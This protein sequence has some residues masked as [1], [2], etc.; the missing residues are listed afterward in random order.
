[1]TDRRMRRSGATIRYGA[2]RLIFFL[3][4][5][6]AVWA[7]VVLLSGGVTLRSG[8]AL[9]SSRDPARPLILS[10][11][12]IGCARL[13]LR[14]ADFRHVIRLVTGAGERLPGRIGCVAAAAVLVFAIAWS[15]RAAGG[16]D[17]S[18]YVLQAEAFATGRLALPSPLSGLLPAASPAIFAPTG[19]VASRVTPFTPVPICGAGLALAMALVSFVS[20]AAIFLVVPAFAALTVWLTF[21]LGRRLDDE[22]TAATS[23]VLLATSPIFLY[24][25]VQ[26]MSDVPAAA[27][28]LGALVLLIPPRAGRTP[29]AEH[30]LHVASGVC[31]AAAVLTRPNI[32]LIVLPLVCLAGWQGRRTA[33][34]VRSLCL[35]G[36]G[37]VPGIVVTM[38]LNVARYGS[39]LASGY[40]STDVLFSFGHVAPNAWRYGRW[41]FETETPFMAAAL[42]APWW[43]W[44]DSRRLA[45]VLA[46]LAAAVL[47]FA[48]YLAYT[49]FDDWWYLRFLL[50]ALPILIV[51]SVA[52]M[53]GVVRRSWRGRVAAAIVMGFALGAWHLSVARTHHVFELQALE[54]RFIITGRY[55]ARAL[56]VDAVVFAVQQ[57]GS[58]RYHG[59]RTTLAWD[60]VAPGAL[61]GTVAWL[62]ARGRS[63]MFVL[64]DGEEPAFRARFSSQRY[65]ALD[66]P[67]VAD[68]HGPVRVRVYDPAAGDDDARGVRR[69]TE[70]VR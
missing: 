65:G 22:V 12:L 38:W 60:A 37:A 7:A 31:A 13:L 35:L 33:R 32:A 28:W 49:V 68:V 45:A 39:P 64:E 18:C 27:L 46:S 30:W 21:L 67:P 17:S 48:T 25:S 66:W 6:A 34:G 55:A 23:A 14:G 43:A 59:G 19:F 36:A 24:Q 20:R 61:D 69:Q 42:I 44:R 54:S 52:V 51:L 57:S 47:T 10:F 40:G 63:P 53:L 2:G 50:P 3:G 56:P 9:L 11:A 41:L 4:T 8:A 26:P 5:L 58:I 16:S 70:F 29:A 1:M 15:T 62:R